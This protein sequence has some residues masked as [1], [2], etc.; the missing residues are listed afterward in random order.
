MRSKDSRIDTT[1][2][3]PARRYNYWLGGDDNFA[4]DRQSGDQIAALLPAIRTAAVE[5]RR[6][7]R[8]AVTHLARDRG[9]RQFLDIGAGIPGA[10][11]THEVARAIAPDSRVVC[12]DNDPIVGAYGRTLADGSAG[13][14]AYL[15]ADLRDPERILT[16][17]RLR[18][19]LDLRRPVGL[20]LLA[21]LHFLSDADQPYRVVRDLVSALPAGSWL[22]VSHATADFMSPETAAAVE[23]A[24]LRSG[25]PSRLRSRTEIARFFE[26]T[27]LIPPG[28]VPTPQWHSDDEP[29]VRSTA[30]DAA[31][32]AGA[33]L[34]G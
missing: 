8:R 30:A 7:L 12:V 11:N 15:E 24:G 14:V 19:T 23:E 29:R 26:G 13:T 20:T 27:S 1:V 18:A 28:I 4:A 32:Y 3:H 16:D 5:N 6:F 34:V 25:V 9:I 21:V 2:A 31:M 22:V 10:G 33:A 17:P